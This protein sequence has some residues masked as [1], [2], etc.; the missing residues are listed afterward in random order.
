MR[1]A[2]IRLAEDAYQFIWSFHHLLLDGWSL[3]LLLKEVF[4]FYEAFCAGRELQLDSRPYGDYI[5]WLQQQDLPRRRHSGGR[6]SGLPRRPLC[7]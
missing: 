4:Q 2:L 6:R 3:P 1:L 7:A 5:A